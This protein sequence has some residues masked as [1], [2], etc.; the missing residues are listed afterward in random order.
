MA[1]ILVVDD[2][3]LVR[4]SLRAMLE[5]NGHDVEEAADGNDCLALLKGAPFDIAIID[6]FMPNKE[7]TET[8][9]ELRRDYPDLKLIAISG[10]GHTGELS[11]L[12]AAISFGAD[13]ALPKPLSESD[14]IFAVDRLLL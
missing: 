7:G 8:I 13:L 2:E 6:I 14:L 10:G 11:Y 5:S 3:E 4:F 12:N 9:M 1:R